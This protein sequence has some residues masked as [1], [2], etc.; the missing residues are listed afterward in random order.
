MFGGCDDFFSWLIPTPPLP[1]PGLTPGCAP[2]VLAPVQV[3]KEE[4]L[5]NF[6]LSEKKPI[7]LYKLLL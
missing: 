4:I 2:V 5:S 6:V 1:L 3:V 7:F